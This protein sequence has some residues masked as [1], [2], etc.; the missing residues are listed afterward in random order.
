M[1]IYLGHKSNIL[2]MSEFENIVTSIIQLFNLVNLVFKYI[3]FILLFYNCFKD[4]HH[5]GQNAT[6]HKTY[7]NETSLYR[8]LE[9]INELTINIE[10]MTLHNG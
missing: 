5:D 10:H 3:V 8:E 9:I 2:F 4:N 7:V 6:I 1:L